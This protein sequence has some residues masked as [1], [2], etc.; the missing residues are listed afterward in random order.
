MCVE[1]IVCNISV[2]FETP[3]ICAV[4]AVICSKLLSLVT[5]LDWVM[6]IITTLSCISMMFETSRSRVMTSS[7][8]QVKLPLLHDDLEL[9]MYLLTYLLTYLIMSHNRVIT[10][11]HRKVTSSFLP[12][13]C[14]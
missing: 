2:V 7:T 5:Y 4:L 6:I 8:L 14:V 1:V 3:C 12:R 9:Q 13:N 11:Q 10:G